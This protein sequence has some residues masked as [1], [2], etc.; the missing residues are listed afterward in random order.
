M[1]RKQ[2]VRQFPTKDEAYALGRNAQRLMPGNKGKVIN[3]GLTMAEETNKRLIPIVV[4][5]DSPAGP[6]V[7]TLKAL[8]VVRRKKRARS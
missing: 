4:Q 3:A 1:T 5:K 6:D 8:R 7:G 2:K